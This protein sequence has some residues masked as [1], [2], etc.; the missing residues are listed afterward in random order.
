VTSAAEWQ[1]QGYLV[2]PGPGRAPWAHHATIL[3]AAIDLQQVRTSF[4]AAPAA[5]PLDA[6][7]QMRP[8]AVLV[9]LFE[10]AGQAR[11][12][13]IRRSSHVGTHRGD[14]AFPGGVIDPGET[15]IA[16]ALREAYEEV[17]IQPADVEAIGQLPDFAATG[18]GFH[19]TPIV[20]VTA[21][22][23]RYVV[24]AEE[25]DGVFD[26]SL[27][28]ILD[29]ARYREET[30]RPPSGTAAE[31]PFFDLDGGTVWGATAEMLLELL[32]VIVG[33]DWL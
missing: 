32:A 25:I 2:R 31:I 16:A 13:F 21:T 4:Q 6:A 12:V 3:P 20:G 28:E 9:A 23:P 33:G 22:P 10:E 29:P 11:V 5:T 1:A 8:A 26:A 30:W 18:S 24:N 15:P 17:G 27:I 19:I 14:V 7:P